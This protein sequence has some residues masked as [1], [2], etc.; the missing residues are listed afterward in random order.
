MLLPSSRLKISS[1]SPSRRDRETDLQQAI[2]SLLPYQQEYLRLAM[3]SSVLICEKS[4]RVG[5]SW[6]DAL[7]SVISAAEGIST[8]YA[9]YNRE[10]ARQY[11]LDVEYW[12]N[13]LGLLTNPEDLQKYRADFDRASVVA[14]SSN[15]NNFRNK[16]GAIVIDEA[17]FHPNL[18]EAIKSALAVGIWG[19]STR[20]I[21]THYG[22]KNPFNLL[23]NA[24]KKGE[25]PFAIYQVSF[26]R[27]LSLGLYE[28]IQ[29]TQNVS[30]PKEE[31]VKSIYDLYGIYSAEELD[32]I[33]R[34]LGAG[35]LFN[36]ENIK[37]ISTHSQ[38]I[39]S[40]RFWDLAA[41]KGGGCYSVGVKLSLTATGYLVEDVKY[42]QYGGIEGDEVIT[43]TA[44][45]DGRSTTVAWEQ[46]PGS[47]SI[48]YSE[49][50]KRQLP[51]FKTVAVRPLGGKVHR[52]LPVAD[53]FGK[54]KI[55]MSREAW[56]G[57]FLS[58]LAEYSLEARS[59]AKDVVD[60]LSGA[61][62]FLSHSSPSP[63]AAGTIKR[64]N[65]L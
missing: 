65:S 11:I 15:P 4:R 30:L 34:K 32:C 56:N 38:S 35:G 62:N 53:A 43:A 12:A 22:E 61:F 8:Y 37:I 47:A 28:K 21:S 36:T 2:N 44:H 55:A 7:V 57:F 48:K 42:G 23:V 16:K 20:V 5:I 13:A 45:T 58:C 3:T 10:S 60:A 17:A 40:V 52:A 63:R 25:N 49:Y 50:M 46:E 59:P 41:T 18:D 54:G 26:Q 9:S 24:T 33:P 31:W 27:A 39:N 51:G 6:A 19:G 29:S 14:V 1:R 64:V